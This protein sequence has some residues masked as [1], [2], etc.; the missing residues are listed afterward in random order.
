M[1]GVVH[2]AFE[3]PVR[4]SMLLLFSLAFIYTLVEL[5]KG[6]AIS[7]F[8]KSQ[9]QSFLLVLL[10]GMIDFMF[11]GYAA[12]VESMPAII[13]T[14][15]NFIPAHHWLAILRGIMLKGSTISDL[16][17]NV[18]WLLVLGSLIGFFSLRYIRKALD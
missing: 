12:P 15:A 13:Q 11:T 8:S 3:V 2:F 6:M 10:V 18:L 16:L 5:G 4:G 17:P 9:H 7:V 1:L 14:V